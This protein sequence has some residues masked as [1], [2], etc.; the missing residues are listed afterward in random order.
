MTPA[1]PFASLKVCA[2]KVQMWSVHGLGRNVQGSLSQPGPRTSEKSLR[3][4]NQMN[5]FTTLEFFL[6][7]EFLSRRSLHIR[8]DEAS[9]I[10]AVFVF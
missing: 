4:S 6:V 8:C 7:R 5:L 3:R 9:R 2:S 1:S 10:V